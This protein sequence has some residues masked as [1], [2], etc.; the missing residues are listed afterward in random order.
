MSI[1]NKEEKVNTNHWVDRNDIIAG[2]G[3][4]PVNCMLTVPKK[5]AINGRSY[6]PG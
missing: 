1:M 4:I 6:G 5:G 3:F 2:Y